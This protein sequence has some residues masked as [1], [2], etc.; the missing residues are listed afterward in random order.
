MD[1]QLVTTHGRQGRNLGELDWPLLTGSDEFNN[2]IIAGNAT[3]R[4]DILKADGKFE[5]LPV[6]DV[7]KQP[8]CARIYMGRLYVAAWHWKELHV[9]AIE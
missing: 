4:I 1:G 5:S 6:V 3:A 8:V 2:I 9:L 7:G